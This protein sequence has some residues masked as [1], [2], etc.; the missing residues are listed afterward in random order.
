MVHHAATSGA[1]RL[2]LQSLVPPFFWFRERHE[3]AAGRLRVWGAVAGAPGIAPD[4]LVA[5]VDGRSVAFSMRR[6][7]YAESA[8]WYLP[9]SRRFGI[10]IDEYVGEA[11]EG[12]AVALCP[13]ETPVDRISQFAFRNFQHWDRMGPTPPVANIERV[14][15]IGATA[16]NYYNNGATD[17]MRFADISRRHG[18]VLTSSTDVLDWGCGCGRLTRYL[19]GSRVV[20]VDI[21]PDNIGWCRDNLD[22]DAFEVVG[23]FP[24]TRFGDGSFDVVIANSVLSHLQM[25]AAQAW[26]AEIA[27]ILRPDGIALLSYHGE[28]SLSGFVSSA[29]E[30]VRRVLATGFDASLAAPELNDVIDDASYYRQTF[31][32]DAFAA[33]LFGSQFAVEEQITGVVSRFQN[34]AVLRKVDGA[35]PGAARR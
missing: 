31:M 19:L 7:E 12:F 2:L 14:S 35:R 23:L 21:D 13:A 24:P 26:L 22:V 32:T 16:Y 4:G 33:E 28:F 30:F 3:H 17:F 11:S 25:A 29:P 6:S 27:R 15:G 34:V 9:E 1:D 10:F 20:G 18:H 8:F 5:L